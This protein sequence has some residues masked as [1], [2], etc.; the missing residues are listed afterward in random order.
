MNVGGHGAQPGPY[1]F[2]FT[3]GGLF[4]HESIALAEAWTSTRDWKAAGALVPDNMF[5]SS[6]S[7][8]TAQKYRTPVI[9]R[10]KTL[11]EAEIE[12]LADCAT[13]DARALTWLAACRYFRPILDY[14]R[15][16]LPEHY[17]RY[18]EPLHLGAIL[19]FIDGLE[20]RANLKKDLTNSTRN[21]L[22]DTLIRMLREAELIDR[23][24]HVLS[25]PISP[26]LRDMLRGREFGGL[27]CLPGEM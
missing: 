6:G 23:D 3:R 11:S 19:S 18:A 9:A 4:L 22:R 7:A 15:E 5:V 12:H 24:N 8:A 21:K 1:R 20:I 2:S 14:A 25:L 17:A 16:V 27:D 13:P 26:E 10:M